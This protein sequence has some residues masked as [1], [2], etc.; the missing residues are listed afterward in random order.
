MEKLTITY[1]N[2]TIETKH[3]S[4]E[5]DIKNIE[6]IR[7]NYFNDTNKDKALKQLK[8]CLTKGTYKINDIYEYYFERVAS[9]TTLYHSKFSIHETLQCNELIQVFLNK[10]KT[11]SKVFNNGDLVKDFK[12]AIRLGGKGITAKAT[13]FPLKECINLINKYVGS[14]NKKI[15]IDTSAGW[16]VRML[17]SAMLNINYIGFDVN[18]ELIIKLNELGQDIQKIKPNWKFKILEQGS[19][20]LNEKCIDTAD[21]ILTSPPYFN[22][23]DYGNNELEKVD[24]IHGDY[25]TWLNGYVMPLMENIKLYLKQGKKALI[26]VKDF[27]NY[28]LEKDFI[29]IGKSKGLV[30]LGTDY[31]KNNQRMNNKGL[32]DNSERVFIFTK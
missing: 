14:G 10:I 19:Q 23:E 4:K 1:N 8:S 11:N 9:K 6:Y 28:T 18:K 17:A 26:N 29:E 20:Y 21:I 16:G 12:T 30:F 7:N 3:A 22:L 24:S 31:L 5:L 27:K 13:N 15:Y 25:E 32:I 2:K